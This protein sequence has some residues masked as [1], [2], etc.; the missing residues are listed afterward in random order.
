MRYV[1]SI[2]LGAIGAYL[3]ILNWGAFYVTYVKKEGFCSWIPL[4]PG[5]IAALAFVL[6][7]NNSFIY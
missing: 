3:I 1:L 6:F 7:P 5:I 2:V 4:V